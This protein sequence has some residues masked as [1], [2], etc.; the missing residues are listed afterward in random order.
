[1]QY[2]VATISRLLKIIGRFC[3]RTLQKRQCSAKETYNLIDPTDRSHPIGRLSAGCI[4]LWCSVVQCGA[5]CCGCMYAVLYN[6]PGR[7]RQCIYL[8]SYVC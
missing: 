6:I 5:V 4:A 3:K 2:G 1:M 7:Q 8:I